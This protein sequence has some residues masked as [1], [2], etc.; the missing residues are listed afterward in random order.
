MGG[1]QSAGVEIPPED[2][3]QSWGCGTIAVMRL[4]EAR[5]EEGLLKPEKPLALT[6]GERVALV[7][8]R[9][10]HPKRWDLDRLAKSGEREDLALAEQGLSE[11]ADRLDGEDHSGGP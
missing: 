9:H 6:P 1:F 7:V 4:I 2:S 10:P 3:D 8:V 5:Y 11:W